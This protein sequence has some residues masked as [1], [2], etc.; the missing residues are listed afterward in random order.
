MRARYLF[1]A[2]TVLGLAAP[3][4]AEPAQPRT[5]DVVYGRRD[6]HALTMDVVVPRKPNGAGVI[7]CISAEYRSTPEFLGM[8]KFLVAPHFTNRGYTVF[9][10]MHSSQPRY[11]VPEIVDDMHRAVRYVKAHAGEYGVDP[12]RLGIAGASSGGHLSLM[13]GCAWREG[14]PNA[15]DEVERESSKVAAVACFFPVTDFVEFDIDDLPA[16]RKPFRTLFDV[17][18][19]D[20]ATN[21]LERVTAA[22]RREL[23]RLYSPVYCAK[24]KKDAAPTYIIHGDADELVPVHQTRFLFDVMRECGATC[25]IDIIRGMGHDPAPA[26]ERLPALIDWLDKQLLGRQPPGKK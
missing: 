8:A 2:V 14:K 6:G 11:T 17:R 9:A 26:Q 18:R 25:E 15:A 23:G 16:I 10:V 22:E 21:R 19:L 7:L 1:A 12:K 20:T 13:M 4:V 3:A 5:K 24:D